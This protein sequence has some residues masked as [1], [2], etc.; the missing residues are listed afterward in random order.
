MI[1][2]LSEKQIEKNVTEYAKAI[3]CLSY[4]FTSPA[5][6]SVPD[7][8]F[9][10]HGGMLLVEFKSP[11]KTATKAQAHCHAKLLEHGFKVFIVD[12]PMEGKRIIDNFVKTI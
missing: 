1:G 7:R 5:Q 9:I 8:L 4:K 12:D 11:G 6:R 2:K 3:G 10:H